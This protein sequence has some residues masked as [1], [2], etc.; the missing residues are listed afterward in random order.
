MDQRAGVLWNGSF[1]HK[2]SNSSNGVHQG[3]VLSPILF[4]VYIDDLLLELEKQGVG[5][6]W[7][8]HFAGAVCHA[9]D[10]VLI[11]PSASALCLMLRTCTQFASSHSLIFNASKTQFKKFS[12]TFSGYNSTEFS[13]CGEQL[14]YTE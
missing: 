8:H 14:G 6:F 10:I 12:C 1:S 13:F 2:F 4:T 3:G 7:N 11:A 9:D 5:C